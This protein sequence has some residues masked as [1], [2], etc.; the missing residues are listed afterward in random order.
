VHDDLLSGYLFAGSIHILM[1]PCLGSMIR[2]AQPREYQ[3]NEVDLCKF[4]HA[5]WKDLREQMK[6]KV[7]PSQMSA[8]SGQQEKE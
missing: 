2:T 5:S 3:P 6:I 1:A 4:M 8:Q 7:L